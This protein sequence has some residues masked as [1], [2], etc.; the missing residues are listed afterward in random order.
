MNSLMVLIPALLMVVGCAAQD[1]E[2]TPTTQATADTALNTAIST[3]VPTSTPVILPTPTDT[4]FPIPTP[5]E[6]YEAVFIVVPTRVPPGTPLHQS[7]RLETAVRPEGAGNITLSPQQKNQM[8]DRGS[9]IKA[10]A[11]CDV[12]FL[13]WEGNIP[14]GS[15]KS[16]NPISLSMDGPSVLYAFCVELPPTPTAIPKPTTTAEPARFGD[17]SHDE[18]NAR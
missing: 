18:R 13:R 15:D 8:Y 9:T 4:P 12:G 5:T 7:W 14:E 17:G 10:T 6:V 16:A 11:N 1:V 3:A 2:A